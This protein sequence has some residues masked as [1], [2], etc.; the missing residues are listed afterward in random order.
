MYRWEN[1][2]KKKKIINHNNWKLNW[3]AFLCKS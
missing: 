1:T 3:N 2:D